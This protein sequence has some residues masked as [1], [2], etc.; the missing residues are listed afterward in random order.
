MLHSFIARKDLDSEMTVVR[1]EFGK[2]ENSP[3]I[4]L[5]KWMQGVAYEGHNY[6]KPTLSNRSDVEN[7]KIE[8][9]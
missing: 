7:V 6:G 3:A 2:G 8:N 4:V 1:N 9:L 5:F